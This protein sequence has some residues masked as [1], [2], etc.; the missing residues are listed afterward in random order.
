MNV[1]ERKKLKSRSFTVPDFFDCP[2]LDVPSCQ[3]KCSRQFGNNILNL[4]K[5]LTNVLL[6]IC[7]I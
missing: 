4:T 1:L 5:N 2:T 3:T 7:F 6:A